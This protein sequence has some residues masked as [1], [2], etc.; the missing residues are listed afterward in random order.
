MLFARA[1]VCNDY[2]PN[3]QFDISPDAGGVVVLPRVASATL[4]CLPEKADLT[5]RVGGGQ[6]ARSCGAISIL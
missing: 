4:A 3:G 2:F 5:Q 6:K 1:Y